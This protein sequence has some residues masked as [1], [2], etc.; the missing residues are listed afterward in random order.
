MPPPPVHPTKQDASAPMTVATPTARE[1]RLRLRKIKQA[2]GLLTMI[3]FGDARLSAALRAI[4]L[5]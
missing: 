3:A 4:S 5:K 2:G 1:N